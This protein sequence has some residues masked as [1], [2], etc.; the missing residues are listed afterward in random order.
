MSKSVL[1]HEDTGNSR[2]Y[3]FTDGDTPYVGHEIKT[4]CGLWLCAC[5]DD[6]KRRV[7]GQWRWDVGDTVTCPTCLMM[8]K[9][10]GR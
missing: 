2:D 5:D 9:E 7:I 3:T 6:P 4:L 8:M 1:S 10:D